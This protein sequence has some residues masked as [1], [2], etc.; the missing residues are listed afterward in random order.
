MKRKVLSVLLAS[1]M[2]FSMAACGNQP[3]EGSNVTPAPSGANTAAPSNTNAPDTQA[4]PAPTEVAKSEGELLA[5]QY[6]GFVETPMDLKG[7]VIKIAC[8][9]D[10]KYERKYDAEGKETTADKDRAVIDILDQIEKDYNCTIEATKIKGKD[11][12]NKLNDDM[13]GGAPEFDII[14]Q[15]VSDTYIDKIL[16]QNLAMDLNDPRVKDIIK[17]DT[18]P[19]KPQSDYGVYNGVQYGVNFVTS[20]SSNDLRNALLFNIDLAEEYKL[21]DIYGMV[22]DGTWTWE[23]F[24][25][26][27]EKIKTESGGT[28]VPCG[29][30]KENLLF[31]MVMSSNNAATGRRD[32]SGKMQFTA[33]E[34]SA[35]QAANWIYKLRQDGYMAPNDGKA[36]AGS[37]GIE[38]AKNSAKAEKF[39]EDGA[40]VFY[41]DF[42]GD[43][44]KLTGNSSSP[45]ETKY[46][47][48][49]LPCPLG[50]EAVKAGD[51]CHG[52][53]YSVDLQ[54]IVNG[55]KNPEEVAAVLVAIANRTS[56]TPENVYD[57]ET[58]LT[59]Q[60]EGSVEM[61]KLMYEDMRSDYSRAYCKI[62]IG[63]ACN[64]I[65]SLEST[66]KE[67]FE[68]IQAETQ[69]IYDGTVIKDM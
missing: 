59:L 26:L 23:K 49:L 27:C 17:F 53:T 30:G 46:T 38:K 60:D 11:V 50:P 24:E 66:P 35:L 13:L 33:L 68:A 41:F 19:W 5:E 64:K 54:M 16:S 57:T 37:I 34:D 15:G 32:A 21:G 2:V 10:W 56:K 51:K 58:E 7:R 8:S 67:A 1:A 42:Y 20:N 31:P 47:F 3:A 43:L 6:N 61:L 52:V 14:D 36:A 48:G 22:K 63:G 28:V 18:N 69:G 65:L 62:G 55:T 4:T 45:I 12:V 29:Y 25:E 9:V 44:Q 39:F 40:C